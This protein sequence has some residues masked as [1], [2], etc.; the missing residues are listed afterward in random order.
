MVGMTPERKDKKQLPKPEAA[1]YL[2]LEIS[3]AF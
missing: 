3:R 2:E 1:P